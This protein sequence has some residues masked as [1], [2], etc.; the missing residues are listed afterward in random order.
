M[1]FQAEKPTKSTAELPQ[2]YS[3]EEYLEMEV[4]SNDR[5][6]YRDGEIVLMTG[7]MP[8]H[9]RISRNLCTVMTMGLQGRSLEVFVT[10][11]RLWIAQAR[12]HTYPDIMVIEGAL[13]LQ[14]GRKDTVVNPTLIVEVLSK[15]TQAYDRGDKFAAYRT[16]PGFQE[17]ILVDQYSQHIE[18]YV[19]T[20]AK[21]WDFQ[22]YDE[23]DT[24]LPLKSINLEIEIAYIYDKVEFVP[25]AVEVE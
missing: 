25:A 18:H 10:D 17:Y 24:V 21:K 4:R 14:S 22:E 15:S 9:N 11:Q 16:I 3:P 5:H 7:A 6:E 2:R 23:T 12:L 8:N 20:S 13:V 1:V 19:K